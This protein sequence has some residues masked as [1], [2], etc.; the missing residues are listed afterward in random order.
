RAP[1]PRGGRA[2]RR[3]APRWATWTC[4]WARSR[5]GLR[6]G[7]PEGHAHLGALVRAGPELQRLSE[8]RD[9][10]EAEAEAR[11]VGPRQHA[12]PLVVDDHGEPVIARPGGHAQWSLAVRI[13]VH[14]DV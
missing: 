10:R 12:A 5:R 13:G 6:T 1:P 7:Q 11:A 9:Q 3:R 2:P 8:R 4:S 14:D